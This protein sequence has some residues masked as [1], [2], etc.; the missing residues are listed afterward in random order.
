MR[1][2]HWRLIPV[3]PRQQLISQWRECVCIAHNIAVK[4][5]PNHILVEPVMDYPLDH[6]DRYTRAVG[7]EMMRR[8]YNWN[9]KRYT[10][11]RDISV[12][13][14]DFAHMDPR[15]EGVFP[16]WHDDRYFEQCYYNLMEKY[17]RG[18]ITDEEWT[19][20]EECRN[21]CCKEKKISVP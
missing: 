8:G 19:K 7:Q 15:I 18:G 6:L 13:W 3:L 17:D 16:G 21:G 14:D 2:W 5:H 1:I 9:W 20:N 10:Q 4:G 11:Q 12:L